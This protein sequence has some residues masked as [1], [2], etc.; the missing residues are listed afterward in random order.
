[1][2]EQLSSHD[3]V[4]SKFDSF[5]SIV[6]LHANTFEIV[7]KSHAESFETI[8]KSLTLKQSAV[9]EMMPKIARLDKPTTPP[10]LLLLLVTPSLV[11]SQSYM[12]I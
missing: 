4:P 9:A 7:Q 5:Y 11:I 2:V 10:P 8:Q 3:S 1:M 12:M 6:Q